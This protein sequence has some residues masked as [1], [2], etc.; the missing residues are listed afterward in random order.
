M[1]PLL[2]AS[3]FLLSCGAIAGFALGGLMPKQPRADEPTIWHADY[4]MDRKPGEGFEVADGKWLRIPRLFADFDLQM[5]VELGEDV[6][7]DLLVRQVEPRLVQ[8]E[9]APFHARFTS[10]RL[11]TG[12]EGPAWL[13]REAA[14]FGEHGRGAELAPGMAATVWVEARGHELRGNVAGKPLGPFRAMDEHGTFSMIARGGKAIVHRLRIEN[15]GEPRAWLRRPW[16]WTTIGVLGAA[17]VLATALARGDRALRVAMLGVLVAAVGMRI[18]GDV[19]REPLLT[20]APGALL[21]AYGGSCVFV[22]FVL[23]ALAWLRFV[24]AV[25]AIVVATTGTVW[26]HTVA[27]DELRPPDPQRLDAVF[28]PASGSTPTEA[29]AQLVRGSFGLHGPAAADGK[30]KRVMLLGGQLLYGGLRDTDT[31]LEPLLR[32]HLRGALGPQVEVVC[33]PTVDGHT[34]QQWSLFAQFYAEG[35]RPH[36]LVFGVS[37]EEARPDERTG[38]P[39]SFASNLT[40]TLRQ[41]RAFGK[42]TGCAIV[43]FTEPGL[44]ADLMAVLQAAHAEGVPLVTADAADTPTTVVGKLVT[45]LLPVLR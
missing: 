20:P 17:L 27:R 34:Q 7:L 19:V 44:P 32:G 21:A 33:L 4:R 8:G 5:D 23:M 40:D 18:A 38:R 43:M 10:L 41:A 12:R 45:A 36:A 24:P 25:L 9:I 1:R 35:H 30:Q 14:L 16:F 13:D 11:S 3:L 2:L 22:A 26:L 31:H 15:R 29:L 37:A 42:A 28:G 6:D 39:R